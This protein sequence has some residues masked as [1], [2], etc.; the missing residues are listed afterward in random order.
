[1]EGW[2]K[3]YR[4]AIG[5]WVF[6]D[7]EVWKI[8]CYCLMDATH[9]K[10]QRRAKGDFVNLDP[11]QTIFGRNEWG[12]RLNIDPNKVNRTISLFQQAEMISLFTVGK[13][14]SV[15]TI[16]NWSE[17]QGEK[18]NKH[19]TN[20]EQ[21]NEQAETAE[22]KDLTAIYEQES[23]QELNK[24]RTHNKKVKNEKKKDNNKLS[25]IFCENSIEYSLATELKNYILKNNEK[26]KVPDDLQKW[27]NDIN[28]II[29]LDKRSENDIRD[30]IKYSQSDKFWQCNILSPAKLRE[31]FDTIYL[32]QKNKGG[33]NVGGNGYSKQAEKPKLDKTKFIANRGIQMPGLQR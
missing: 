13:K 11:G 2:I 5:N 22:N 32:Q 1:M 24:S 10:T 27:A 19:S 20:Q 12:K 18:L 25:S 7:A 4:A 21:E 3:L 6:H 28:K 23:E 29:R 17:Y 14:Y 9:T 26:A 16:T 15:I 33:H 8:W 31:K 30:I